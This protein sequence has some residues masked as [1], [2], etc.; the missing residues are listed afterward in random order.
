MWQVIFWAYRR[1]GQLGAKWQ[2]RMRRSSWVCR[3]VDLRNDLL[4]DSKCLLEF[5]CSPL[6][7]NLLNFPVWDNL[8]RRKKPTRK[9]LA[10]G[11][12]LYRPTK[13]GAKQRYDKIEKLRMASQRWLPSS[14]FLRRRGAL[15]FCCTHARGSLPNWC[16]AQRRLWFAGQESKEGACLSVDQFNKLDLRWNC[17]EILKSFT[18]ILRSSETRRSSFVSISFSPGQAQFRERVARC[19]KDREPDLFPAGTQNLSL[20]T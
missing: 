3:P 4:F 18:E 9:P 19:V 10:G 5:L 12:V 8:Q 13:L 6:S 16:G 7:K 15:P 2:T 17:D 20:K 1:A 14:R 11:L